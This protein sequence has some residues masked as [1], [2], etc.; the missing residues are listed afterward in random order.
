MNKISNFK[1]RLSITDF[2]SFFFF[3]FE[4]EWSP[5]VAQHGLFRSGSE[6]LAYLSLV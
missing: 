4:K 5:Y 2:F 6:Y 3:F 1:N